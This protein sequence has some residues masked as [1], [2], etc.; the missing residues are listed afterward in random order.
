MHRIIKCIT[1]EMMSDAILMT[2]ESG[3]QWLVYR[4]EL[5]TRNRVLSVKVATA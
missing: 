4:V 3:W 5:Q 1:Q 2:F